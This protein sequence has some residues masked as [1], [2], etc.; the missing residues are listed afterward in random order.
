MRAQFLSLVL[1][2]AATVGAVWIR[3]SGNGQ[4]ATREDHTTWVTETLTRMGT[5]K[6]GM[7]RKDL[8]VVFTTEGGLSTPLHRRYVSRDCPYFK[9]DVDFEPVGRP[10]LNADGRMTR[11]EDEQDR[12]VTISR[13]YL[14][15]RVLD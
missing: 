13:P 3:A 15:L 4:G 7:T 11:I 1:V 2:V 5:I 9:V 10:S 6:P 8:L 14:E 12:I